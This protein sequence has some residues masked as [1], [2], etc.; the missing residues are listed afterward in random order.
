MQLIVDR[1]GA[2]GESE[3]LKWLRKATSKLLPK[4]DLPD[5]MFEADSWTGFLDA[6]A[7]PRDLGALHGAGVLTAAE[8]TA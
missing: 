1:F 5:Q 8:L 6:L 7:H 2:L 4:I 3:S